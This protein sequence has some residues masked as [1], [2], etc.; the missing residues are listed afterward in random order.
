MLD[1]NHPTLPATRQTEL[2]PLP[3]GYDMQELSNQW[4]L[5]LNNFARHLYRTSQ[6]T[7]ISTLCT[8][9]YWHHSILS[10][11]YILFIVSIEPNKPYYYYWDRKEDSLNIFFRLVKHLL[12][13][14]NQTQPTKIYLDVSVSIRGL[15]QKKMEPILLLTK[16]SDRDWNAK[17]NLCRLRLI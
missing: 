5:K 16:A 9:Q 13:K 14:L 11:A 2:Q 7:I 15:H 17:V 6:I 10:L 12:W 8:V 3:T 1:H 4:W